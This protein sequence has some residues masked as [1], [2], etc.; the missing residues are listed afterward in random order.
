MSLPITQLFVNA[1]RK[2]PSN[3]ALA[4]VANSFQYARNLLSQLGLLD[5]DTYK[6]GNFSLLQLTSGCIRDMKEL[7]RKFCREVIKI[8]L[9][10]VGPGQED[11]RHILRNQSGSEDYHNFVGSLGWPIEITTHAGYKGRL[12]PD[13]S[14]GRYTTY[15]CNDSIEVVFHDVTRMPTDLNDAQQI[16]KVI[17][18]IFLV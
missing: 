15:F 14:N 2:K 17:K 6:D 11:E 7:D 8:A 12:E 3:S 13:G 5:Y 4:T 16:R 10:Y 18:D 1:S 9:I